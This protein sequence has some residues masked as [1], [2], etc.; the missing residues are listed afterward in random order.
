ML[1]QIIRYLAGT[2]DYGITYHKSY[3]QTAPLNTYTDAG[4]ANTDE[5]KSTT[6]IA[7][8]SAG[9]AVL[10]K[11]KKQ[12]LSALSTTEAEYIALAH[13]GTEARWLRNLYTELGFPNSNP[14]LI[15]CDNLGAISMAENPFITPRLRHIDLKYHSIRQLVAKKVIS[16]KACCDAEQTADILTKP[17]PRPKHKQHTSELGVVPV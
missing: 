5:K 14:L 12:T 9:G 11:S 8:I 1:K 7:I 17:L 2:K 16:I 13:S 4:F 6:R 10:W 3:K 15:R